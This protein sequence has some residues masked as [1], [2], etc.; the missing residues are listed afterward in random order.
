MKRCLFIVL[1]LF[2]LNAF[3]EMHKGMDHMSNMMSS[4]GESGL[5]G[6]FS[7]RYKPMGFE[8]AAD[9]LTYRARVGWMG[10]VNE[11][12]KWTVGLSTATEQSF[13]GIRLGD[14][15]LEQAYVTYSPMKGLSLKVGK[16]GWLPDFHKA[17]VLYSE[18]LYKAG[19]MLKY[20]QTMSDTAHWYAKVGA[21]NLTENAPIADGLT[22]K[23]KV[24]GHFDVSEGMMLGVYAG[25][26]HDGL[27]KEDGHTAKTLVQAG[28]R[29]NVSSMEV[30]VGVS[31]NYLA[32]ADKFDFD[33]YTVGLSVGNAGKANS[34]EMGDFG[35]AVSYYDL[36]SADVISSWL[37]E[38][39][40]NGAGKG[41][42]VRGQYNLWDNTSLV[43]KYAHNL[44]DGVEEANNLV[45][46]LMFVF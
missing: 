34:V 12:V 37:N 14:I 15:Q 46:E 41:V 24:G 1:A 17:G 8:E 16:S 29:L 22:V 38:D 40:V 3:A 33:S 39:Y 9:Q 6:S 36:N 43:A 31:A 19:A 44:G 25:A 30:P 11:A 20:M 2:G 18:Q 35:L 32:N 23:A 21:Y 13:A 5:M 42:A 4:E 26:L 28:L 27:M 10:D 45:A 7:L